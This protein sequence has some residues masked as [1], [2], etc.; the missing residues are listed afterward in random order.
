MMFGYLLGLLNIHP[1][2]LLQEVRSEKMFAYLEV[3]I[4]KSPTSMKQIL[5][6]TCVVG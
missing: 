3:A 2:I 4:L 5:E 6:L 1:E